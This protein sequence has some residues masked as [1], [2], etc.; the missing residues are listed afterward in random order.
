LISLFTG[1]EWPLALQGLRISVTPLPYGEFYDADCLVNF[2]TLL[3]S[4]AGISTCLLKHSKRSVK[5]RRGIET[6]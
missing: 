3:V 2:G 4:K 5:I 6:H 1:I